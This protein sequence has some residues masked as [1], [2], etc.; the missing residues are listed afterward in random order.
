M[1]S[2]PTMSPTTWSATSLAMAALMTA[3]MMV[4][5]MLPSIAPTIRHHHRRLRSRRIS[6]A[7]WRTAVFFAGYAGVWAAIGLALFAMHVGLSTMAMSS[8]T[9]PHVQPWVGAVVLCGG[10]LQRSRWKARQLRRCSPTCV[11]TAPVSGGVGSPWRDGCRLGIDCGLSCAAPMAVLLAAG[12]MD[13]RVMVLTTAAIT[14]ERVA[15]AGARIARLT[16][17]VAV[18]VGLVMFGLSLSA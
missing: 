3:A 12:L 14:A 11:H 5:M 16:G 4:A 1:S 7:G 17:S 10:L 9:D 2:M 15:P 18:I 13:V 6:R 8:P